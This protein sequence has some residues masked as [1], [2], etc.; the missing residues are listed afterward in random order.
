[1]P[2][3]IYQ[4]PLEK[5]L[6]QAE[7]NP[8]NH[9]IVSLYKNGALASV[10]VSGDEEWRLELPCT[11]IVFRIN[12]EGDLIAVIGEEVLIFYDIRGKKTRSI[13][14]DKKIRSLD[15]Y[16]NCAV[17][18]GFT[19]YYIIISPGG[20]KLK[21][22][23]FDFLIHQIKV[24]PFTDHVVIYN[25]NVDL[26][27]S[28]IDGN[29]EWLLEN[30]RVHGEIQVSEKG[31]L[32]CFIKQPST[33]V[34]FDIEGDTCFE[35]AEPSTV[36]QL[37]LSLDGRSLLVLG[38]DNRM[39][40]K[41]N[42]LHTVWENVFEH[43]IRL[44]RISGNGEFFLTVDKDNVLTCYDVGAT[45]KAS[46]RFLELQTDGRITNKSA[47]WSA[48]PGRR[49]RE[50]RLYLLSVNS[51]GNGI[52]AVGRDRC[53]F[54]MDD[55]NQN[56]MD[57][58]FPAFI[59]RIGMN[60]SFTRGYVYGERQIKTIDFRNRTN[61]YTIFNE[62]F[63]GKP[64]VN[65]YHRK[66]F[67]L[68]RSGEMWVYDFKGRLTGTFELPAAYQEGLS[69]EEAG[70]VVYR[71]HELAAFSEQGEALFKYPIK[72][73]IGKLYYSDD[74]VWGI[75]KGYALIAVDVAKGFPCLF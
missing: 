55:K 70:I 8:Q 49:V 60:D 46:S 61:T 72:E 33:I 4:L 32:C 31:R 9:S 51:T 24:I 68:S 1:M 59:E 66:I 44:M 34:Q 57:V 64:L 50:N 65:F 47:T 25:Q 73:G 17:L 36:K 5:G 39:K 40:L 37:S 14:I 11:P 38:A 71:D 54:F 6:L 42:K 7:F 16:R 58:S 18:S 69:C 67:L 43:R 63:R 13:A 12:T 3:S 56:S 28:D 2:L 52:G 35:T 30:Y 53:I 74:K 19:T 29:I 62:P 45:G 10:S 75:T 23:S 15:F 48:T 41:D 22:I 21:T 27:C 20:K 26:V